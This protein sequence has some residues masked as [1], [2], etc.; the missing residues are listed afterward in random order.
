ML[1]GE[2][3]E[4]RP[5]LEASEAVVRTEQAAVDFPEL[6]RSVRGVW[7]VQPE[8]VVMEPE[9]RHLREGVLG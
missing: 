3:A 5:W 4:F 8:C 6:A 7:S 1:E 9:R 2:V